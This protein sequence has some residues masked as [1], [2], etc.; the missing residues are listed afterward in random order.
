MD[1]DVRAF[2]TELGRKALEQEWAG[3]HAMLAPWLRKT[4]SVEKVQGFFED[5]YR[6][7]LEANGA[8]GSHHPEYPEPQLG[9]DSFCEVDGRGGDCRRASGR[10]L[11]PGAY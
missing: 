4:C 3:V 9:F 6:A 11:E 7:T 10:V 1:D 2:G 5:E 8:E